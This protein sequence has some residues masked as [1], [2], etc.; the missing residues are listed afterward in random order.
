MIDFEDR[1]VVWKSLSLFLLNCYTL[2]ELGTCVVFF[3]F[4]SN[5][6]DIFHIFY[7]ITLTGGRLFK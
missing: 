3:N 6:N 4:V 5:K 7:S 2:T 1:L